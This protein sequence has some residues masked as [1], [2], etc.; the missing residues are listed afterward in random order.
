MNYLL[1]TDPHF[2]DT[3]LD[4]Y[5]WDMF[6]FLKVICKREAINHI[7]CLGDLV[8]RKDRH[9]GALVNRLIEEFSDLYFETG[10]GID[11]LA[12]NHDMPLTGPYFWNFINRIQGVRYIREWEVKDNGVFYLPYSANPKKEWPDLS[13][14]KAIFM[15]QTVTGAVLD[16]G[17]VIPKGHDLPELP[18]TPIYSG[19]VHRCQKIKGIIY[20][21][22]CHPIK[23]SEDWP[24]G[25][26]IIHNDDFKNPIY[27]PLPTIRRTILDIEN[28]HDV[29]Q[30]DLRPGDQVRIR[31]HLSPEKMTTWPVEEEAIKNWAATN[32]IFLA[33]VEAKLVGNTIEAKTEDEVKTLEVMTPDE[34]IKV[35][36]VTE[37]LDQ[38]VID[39]GLEILKETK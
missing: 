37:K 33:S 7:V 6:K 27:A 39:M 12:G 23:F 31:Y 22:C 28:F 15:H 26:H 32:G 30:W 35:F 29:K 36:G 34:V 18:D 25:V 5:R 10:A 11:I 38:N 17:Y 1:F 20:I 14:A 8:D 3:P 9:T 19:D 21:G 2:T 4:A 13:G 16:G 24:N